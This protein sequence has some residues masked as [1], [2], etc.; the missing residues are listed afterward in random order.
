MYRDA[1]C[2][3][4]AVSHTR[5]ASIAQRTHVLL[6]PPAFGAWLDDRSPVIHIRK[7]ARNLP[8]RHVHCLHG[9]SPTLSPTDPVPRGL[10]TLCAGWEMNTEV[11]TRKLRA[12]RG[13]RSG[14]TG[15]ETCWSSSLS[16]SRLSHTH[17]PLSR[18]SHTHN[19]DRDLFKLELATIVCVVLAKVVFDLFLV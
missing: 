6:A 14:E 11:Y 15:T 18:L 2:A 3:V 1:V 13:G 9:P 17:M 10:L 19:G 7:L 8:L 4:L 5:P 12:R 16:L